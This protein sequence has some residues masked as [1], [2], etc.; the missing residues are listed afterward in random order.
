M[1]VAEFVVVVIIGYL[2]GAIPFGLVIGRLVKG[3]DVRHYGSG[4]TGA[5]N[6]MR[7]VG[8]KFGVLTIALDLGKAIGAVVLAKVIIGDS[9][10]SLGG[11]PL[12]W[13]VAQVM[14]G[15]AVVVGHNW[16]VFAKFKG[17]RGVT[18]FFGTMFAIYPPAA[19]FGTEIWATVALGSKYMSLGS[20][21]GVAATWCLMIPLTIAYDLPPI[22]LAYGLAAM[23]L[24]IYQH[25]DNISR[26]RHGKERRLGEKARG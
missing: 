6:V 3:V 17:G 1:I 25:R 5:T 23:A 10:V 8:T 21:L 2:L 15:V 13:Q 16:P 19:L 14:S 4:R 18:T 7:A 26:L 11:F 24:V 22:Y 12:H 9:F 20:I